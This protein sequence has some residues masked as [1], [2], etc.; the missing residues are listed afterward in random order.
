V[1]ERTTSPSHSEHWA[2]VTFLRTA[3]CPKTQRCVS[4]EQLD[5]PSRQQLHTGHRSHTQGRGSTSL[6][7]LPPRSARFSKEGEASAS[8]PIHRA[9]SL[10]RNRGLRLEGGLISLPHP[11]KGN[12]LRECSAAASASL[13]RPSPLAKQFGGPLEPTHVPRLR[14][15]FADFPWLHFNPLT[16][17]ILLWR[18]DAEVRYG[19]GATFRSPVRVKS[20]PIPL[21]ARTRWAGFSSLFPWLLPASNRFAERGNATRGSFNGLA[22]ITQSVPGNKAATAMLSTGHVSPLHAS[23]HPRHQCL[24]WEG[25][26]ALHPPPQPLAPQPG[27]SSCLIFGQGPPMER[28]RVYGHKGHPACPTDQ[29]RSLCRRGQRMTNAGDLQGRI[30]FSG[31]LPEELF[32]VAIGVVNPGSSPGRALNPLPASDLR[33]GR[34][35]YGVIAAVPG[36]KGERPQKPPRGT[37]TL[38]AT[39]S[40][41]RP[42]R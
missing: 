26:G 19:H 36:T 41:T 42:P 8:V 38:V 37:Y 13:L 16:R 35:G 24:L 23:L 34:A 31:K 5:F 1:L 28:N 39:I 9:T 29:A 22:G 21:R 14:E 27:R 6:L 30:P 11:G 32:C 3:R 4:I 7:P 33:H 40:V 2:E 17:S 18:P 15:K 25:D 12:P 10:H 20:S